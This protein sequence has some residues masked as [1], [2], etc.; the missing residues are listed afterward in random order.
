M[1]SKVV[2]ASPLSRLIEQRVRLTTSDRVRDLMVAEEG[3]R[4]LLKGRAPSRHTKQL[5]LHAALEF[6]SGDE[7]VEQIEVG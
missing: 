7:L 1:V 5:A 2:A 3:G 6:L 4:V